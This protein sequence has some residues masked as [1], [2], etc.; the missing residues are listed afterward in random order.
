[1][2]KRTSAIKKTMPINKEI[3]FF[4]NVY[5]SS[6]RAASVHFMCFLKCSYNAFEGVWGRQQLGGRSYSL[7]CVCGILFCTSLPDGSG[8]NSWGE[9]DPWQCCWPSFSG[10]WCRYRL[11][12]AASSPLYAE[13][14]SPPGARP[15]CAGLAHHTVTQLVSM[16]SMEFM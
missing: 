13:Q 11:A 14:A 10:G 7:A 15:F 6:R 2:V 8:S 5:R 9:L 1:M 4:K 12:A 16:L 3:G